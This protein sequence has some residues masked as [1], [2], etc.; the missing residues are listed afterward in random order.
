MIKMQMTPTER[1]LF[2]EQVIREYKHKQ[3]RHIK[4]RSMYHQFRRMRQL[5]PATIVVGVVAAVLLIWYR[6]FAMFFELLLSG[7]I[8]ITLIAT[9]LSL[10]HG[11]RER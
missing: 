10:L 7:I 1:R 6:G 3:E 5:A 2:K 8:W 9:G 11:P 4:Q